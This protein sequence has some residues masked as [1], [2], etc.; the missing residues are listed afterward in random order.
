LME[1]AKNELN[2]TNLSICYGQTETSPVNCQTTSQDPYEKQINTVGK[3]HLNV[4]IQIK[5][6][7]TNEI[8]PRGQPGELCCRGYSVMKQYW[9]DQEVI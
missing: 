7:V 8:V 9:N 1:R 6:P 4:E 5:D 2:I 3:P